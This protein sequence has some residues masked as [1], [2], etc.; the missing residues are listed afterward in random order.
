MTPPELTP[1]TSLSA[2][3]RE[4]GVQIF[5]LLLNAVLVPEGAAEATATTVEQIDRE[6]VG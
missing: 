2:R 4:Q 3:F 6:G 5:D 1:K